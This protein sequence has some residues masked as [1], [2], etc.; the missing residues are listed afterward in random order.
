MGGEEKRMNE[1]FFIIQWHL[2][3]NKDVN[4]FSSKFTV[5]F[6]NKIFNH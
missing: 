5:N 2:F 6:C 1:S 4:K 3:L